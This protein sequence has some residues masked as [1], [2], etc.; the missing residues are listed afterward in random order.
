MNA[1]LLIG[2][3]GTVSTTLIFSVFTTNKPI[4]QDIQWLAHASVSE[5]EQTNQREHFKLLDAQY[6]IHYGS[7]T[8]PIKVIEFFSFQC[9]H[10]LKLFKNDFALIKAQLIDTGL[11]NFTFHPVPQ[12]LPTAQALICLEKLDEHEK[13]LFLE[14]I[15]EEDDPSD[16]DLM[17]TLMMTAMN[18][19]QKPVPELE[20]HNFLQEHKVFEEIYAFIKQE[21]IVA[22]PTVEINGRLFP[23][24]IPDYHFIKSFIQD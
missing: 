16:S 8:A 12:D 9:A 2:V 11:V 21:K 17:S 14:V 4:K 22:V 18:I 1:L 13:R 24:E 7:D 23:S 6:C 3:I 19:F 15:L 20:D 10:C 5:N